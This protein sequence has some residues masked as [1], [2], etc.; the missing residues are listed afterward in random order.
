MTAESAGSIYMQIISAFLDEEEASHTI[1]YERRSG[2]TT[3]AVAAAKEIGATLVTSTTDMKIDLERTTGMKW[4]TV[5]DISPLASI[6]RPFIADCLNKLQL[7]QLKE[8][9]SINNRK[10]VAIKPI[11]EGL[12]RVLKTK[13]QWVE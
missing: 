3:A 11:P 9:A 5:G 4:C 12:T 8:I 1:F 2:A 6:R 7:K 13:I 10:V